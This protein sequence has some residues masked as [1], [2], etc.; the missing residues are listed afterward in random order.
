M[1][2]VFELRERVLHHRQL[3]LRSGLV[4]GIRRRVELGNFPR[5][6]HDLDLELLPPLFGDFVAVFQ[7]ARQRHVQRHILVVN[8]GQFAG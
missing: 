7:Q 6:L 5:D 3:R 2:N 4:V 1:E 8:A